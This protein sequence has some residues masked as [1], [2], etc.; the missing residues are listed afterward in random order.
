MINIIKPKEIVRYKVLLI[1][2]KEID[3]KLEKLVTKYSVFNI[4]NQKTL[5]KQGEYISSGGS[6]NLNDRIKIYLGWFMEDIIN[7]L[8]EGYTL[9]IIEI[10]RS[11]GSTRKHFLEV[12]NFEYEDEIVILD[13]LEI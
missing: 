12:L 1:A 8:D 13:T 7:A 5:S 4:K 10:H 3:E 6:F 2:Y 9:D 11:Y